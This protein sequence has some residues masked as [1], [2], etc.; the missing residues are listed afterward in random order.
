MTLNPDQNI[1]RVPVHLFKDLQI[2]VP[3]RSDMRLVTK[4]EYRKMVH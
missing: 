2:L 3:E 4:E 1:L